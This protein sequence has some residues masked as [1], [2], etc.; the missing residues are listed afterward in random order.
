[1]P[2]AL[3]C[4]VGKR[5][6]AA[7]IAGEAAPRV[8]PSREWRQWRLACDCGESF[9]A[10]VNLISAGRV[11]RCGA[12]AKLAL[13][14]RQW[15]HGCASQ[16]RGTRGTPEYEIWG[17]MKRRCQNKNNKDYPR[18]GAR[19]IGI[20]ERWQTFENFLADMG[21]RPTLEH[22][23]ERKDN[24]RGYEPDNCVWATL[25]VQAQN[26]RSNR[27]VPW[28]GRSVCISALAREAGLDKGTLAKR[29]NS[30]LSV[31]AA[32][33]IP[34]SL[35][36]VLTDRDGRLNQLEHDGLRQSTRAWAKQTGIARGTIARRLR[37]GWSVAEALSRPTRIGNYTKR[38]P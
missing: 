30:G 10:D 27:K 31:E 19:G 12:C 29:L 17:G 35:N 3:A 24:A 38:R 22:S 21:Q 23:I 14:A 13:R 11:N 9:T 1:M 20:C 34:L 8:T 25:D 7:T 26:K 18:Y 36:Q 5:V 4:P 28:R 37:N 32:V 2:P 33:T 15:R 6:A 16:A